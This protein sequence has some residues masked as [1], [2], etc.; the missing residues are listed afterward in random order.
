MQPR[1]P[2]RALN[3]ERYLPVED[4]GGKVRSRA[5]DTCVCELY[6][7]AFLGDLKW[8]FDMPAQVVIELELLRLGVPGLY[9]NMLDD[10]D[11]HTA[12]TTITAAGITADLLLVRFSFLVTQTKII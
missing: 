11:V 9:N 4:G 7:V 2:T 3:G 6:L 12:K 5:A 8:C 10:I 1:L